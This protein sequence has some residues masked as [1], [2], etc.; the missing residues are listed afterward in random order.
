M[1][2]SVIDTSEVKLSVADDSISLDAGDVINIGT[3][4]PSY[5]G[6]YTVDPTEEAQTLATTDHLM[7]DDVTVSAI[8]GDYIG[9]EVPEKTSS[10]LTALGDTVSA[11]AGYYPEGASKAVAHGSAKAPEGTV[12]VNPILEV[13]SEG[14]I[15]A[16]VNKA[17]TLTPTVVPGYISSGTAGTLTAQ[18]STTYQ[19]YNRTSA[20]MTVSGATVTAPAGYY[21]DDATK[22]V[23]SGTAGTPTAT[24][25]TV[26][27][28]AI[29]VTPSVT[30]T[31]GYIT[32]GTKTGTA[33]SVS[34][35][36][37]TS[38]TKSI[39]ANGTGIDVTEYAAVNVA[40]PAPAPNLQNKTKSYTP[41]ESQ[42]TETISADSGYDGLDEVGITVGA[43]S[44][45]YVGSGITQRTSSDLSAS[46][47]TVTAPAGY[48]ASAAQKSVAS[49]SAG[50]PTATKG[51]VNNH[52]VSV[53]PSVTNTTGY[54]TGSTK[55]GTAVTVSASELVSGSETKTSNGTYDVTN[56]AELVVNVSGGGGTSKNTQVVQGT[57]RTNASTMTAIGAEMTVS[58]SGT[59]DVYWSGM[60]SNT[61]SSYTWATQ[62][63]I[64]GTA[65]GSENTS[66][67]NNVQNIHLSN[68]SLTANQ[69]IR[70]RG[71][72]T[73]GTSYYM[74]APTLVIVEA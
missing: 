13:S 34:A 73:R 59:Y 56:L 41:T 7:T 14:V 38:G 72:N 23:E 53:T 9:S 8:P 19:M 62:L 21:D 20:D 15:T 22:S 29:S 18:G 28:H 1:N 25:G 6:P 32:G 31:T 61:S 30:N 55:T 43:I 71:R 42:Q 4:K 67:S 49:G 51:T 17:L 57:T 64:D 10:D 44:S 24:K 50:T 52:S 48:Y 27:N 2:L 45:T 68:V 74:Y 40:V 16:T 69:K 46:G 35:S 12:T 11:P 66:W 63:Y 26:S 37:V 33:V 58:K 60:R 3:T 70:V 47:A 36:E 5:E 65:Y 39:T 54:I